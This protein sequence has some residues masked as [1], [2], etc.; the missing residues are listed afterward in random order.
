MRHEITTEDLVR[1]VDGELTAEEARRVE[2]VGAEDPTVRKTIR[3]LSEGAIL[4]RAAYGEA[5]HADPPERLLRSVEAALG[6][7]VGRHTNVAAFPAARMRRWHIPAAIAA[8][9]AVV[10]LGLGGG[11]FVAGARL[12]SELAR[13][14]AQ[15]VEDRLIFQATL[16]RALEEKVSGT[17][18]QWQNTG[19][20]MGGSVTP[21]RTFKSVSG[22]W[23]RE[24]AH[25]FG[26][27]GT[28]ETRHAIA[29][30]EQ[31]GAWTTRIP[32]FADS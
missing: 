20:G 22:Q 5:L 1:Y 7:R 23:C 21:I 27:G 14:E 17:T 12:D 6:G 15:R 25:S 13:I 18:V 19:T 10:A 26:R 30:R 2:L 28:V 11:Y 16:Q 4:V 31:D 8:S 32:T 9:L 3:D 29:C 24:Y